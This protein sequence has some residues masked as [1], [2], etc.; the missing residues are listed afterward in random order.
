MTSLRIIVAGAVLTLFVTL[1]AANWQAASGTAF[2]TGTPGSVEPTFDPQDPANDGGDGGFTGGFNPTDGRN[3]IQFTYNGCCTAP[4]AC[5]AGM[6]PGVKVTYT[7][8]ITTPNGPRSASNSTTCCPATC[9]KRKVTV[10]ENLGN[11]GGWGG[12]AT[13]VS[14]TALV[15]CMCCNPDGSTPVESPAWPDHEY[16]TPLIL[17]G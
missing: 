11:G 3:N 8:S 14:V 15:E 13:S 7:V 16:T 5:P 17:M 12:A 1:A 2:T 4:P 6:Q 9:C 10:T